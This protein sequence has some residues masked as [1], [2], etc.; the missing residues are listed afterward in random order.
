MTIHVLNCVSMHPLLPRWNI[1]GVCLLV[2]TDEGP[3]LLDTGLGLQDYAHPSRLLRFLKPFLGIPKN[4]EQCAVRQVVKV[5]W[6]PEKIR[7]IILTHLHFD[8]AG[9]LADFPHAWV[10]VYQ[11]E[12]AAMRK[13]H[14]LLTGWGT[15]PP[16]FSMAR[17]G[18]S[19]MR[20]MPAGSIL[21]PSAWI[22][23]RKCT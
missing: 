13:P 12:Y 23:G 7:H 21:M 19:T 4:T 11:P 20:S 3:V 18:S 9:G 10:H 6:Q 15:T 1:G 16:I 22:S 8:H 17:N 14:S 2:E 5:G